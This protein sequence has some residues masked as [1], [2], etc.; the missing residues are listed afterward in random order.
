MH[1]YVI[2]SMQA[3]IQ[4]L[5]DKIAGY[6]VPG[7]VLVSLLTLFCWVLIGFH[8]VEYITRFFKRQVTVVSDLYCFFTE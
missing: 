6:F 2:V 8:N 7:V 5:A 3:P 4:Q 1:F